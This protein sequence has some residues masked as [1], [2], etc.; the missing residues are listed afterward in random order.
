LQIQHPVK[1]KG[2][3]KKGRSWV[4]FRLSAIVYQPPL[5]TGPLGAARRRSGQISIR[6]QPHICTAV[7]LRPT[8]PRCWSVGGTSNNT[9]NNHKPF[10]LNN[11]T[12]LF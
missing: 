3:V 4:H 7:H 12:L 11:L 10:S 9:S 6:S 8:S 1:T 5:D 2:G